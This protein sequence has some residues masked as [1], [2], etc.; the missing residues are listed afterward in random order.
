VAGERLEGVGSG[1]DDQAV[2]GLA[3]DDGAVLAAPAQAL[4]K[5][6]NVAAAGVAGKQVQLLQR[7]L[8]GA[9]IHRL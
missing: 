2:R 9:Q 8:L 5:E 3:G 7:H 1:E 4:Q 6:G